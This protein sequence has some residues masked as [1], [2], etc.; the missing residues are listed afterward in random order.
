[1]KRTATISIYTP[2]GTSNSTA[3]DIIYRNRVLHG[4]AGQKT[5]QGE[6]IQKAHQWAINQGFTN[7]K[8]EWS[9]A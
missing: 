5:E 4:F 3:V 6:M 9:K 2:W 1:M 7:T 8:T